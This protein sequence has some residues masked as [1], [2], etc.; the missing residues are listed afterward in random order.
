MIKR[1]GGI[2][3]AL[4][5]WIFWA[6]DNLAAVHTTALEQVLAETND[7]AL[8]QVV[9]FL[10]K[11]VDFQELY[12]TAQTLR[13]EE[14]RAYVVQQ[15]KARFERNGSAL[16][17]TLSAAKR[18]E[19]VGR[20]RPLWIA[21]AVVCEV[22][23][24][25]LRAC[26]AQHPEIERVMHDRRFEN[27]L[28]DEKDR[29]SPPAHLDYVAWGVAD[30]G[31]VRVWE[32]FGIYGQGVI[33]GMMDSGI[34]MAHPDLATRIWI[35]PGEDLNGNGSIEVEERNLIDDD[36]NGYID[37]F[38]GWN[39]DEDN[40]D[41]SDRNGHGTAT[42][43]IVAGG[44]T[45]CDTVGIAPEA[46]LMILS[47]Y[48][49]QS[50]CWL[51]MQYASENG[52]HLISSSV[53]FWFTDCNRYQECP[54]PLTWRQ[55]N[56]IELAAGLV[57]VNSTGN[58][59]TS[60]FPPP[61]NISV[62]GCSPPPWLSPAQ[63]LVGGV[64]SII[65]VTGYQ[66]N[67]DHY[68]PSGRG[69]SAW[70][71][72]DLCFHPAMPHCHDD[73]WPVAYQ[74]YPYQGGAHQGLLK[75]EI[76]APTIVR[77]L[78]RGGGCR[79]GFAGTS[80][81]APHIGGTV[82]LMMSA[83]PGVSPEEVCRALKLTARDA[84][85]PGEDS[86]FGAGKVD[87]Y[88]AVAFLLDS[89]GEVTGLVTDSSTGLPLEEVRVTTSD[90][91][92]VF[93]G[94]NGQYHLFVRPGENSVH[95]Y[96]YGYEQTSELVSVSGGGTVTVNQRLPVAESGTLQGTVYNSDLVPQAGVTVRI[97]DTPL[98]PLETEQ[99][100]HFE[101]SVAAGVYQVVASAQLLEADTET[102]MISAS[103]TTVQDFHLNGSPMLL[104]T[105]P[106]S[107]G[108]FAW[109]SM[110]SAGVAYNWI[111]INPVHGGPGTLLNIVED[112]L[113]QIPLPFIF[114]FYGE[115]YDS[116]GITENGFIVLGVSSEGSYPHYPIPSTS[117]PG[118]MVAPFW[119]DFRGTADGAAYVYYF[120]AAEHRFI[121]EWDSA[122]FFWWP[123]DRA[124]F[125]VV[126]YDP[127]HYETETGDGP[128]LFQYKRVDFDMYCTVGIENAAEDDGIQYLFNTLLDS[129]A[130]G[131]AASRSIYFSTRL[132]SVTS[133]HAELPDVF[134]L[135]PCYPN[136]FNPTTTFEWT[137][138]R[139]AHVR[140]EIFDILGRHVA[141]VVEG[142]WPAGLHRYTF[143]GRHLATGIYFARFRADGAIVQSRKMLLL[144]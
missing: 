36:G 124:T 111:E 81:A 4:L 46:Q 107:Y 24:A 100:G 19:G 95:F 142:K 9:V 47:A 101:T 125:E 55:I 38:Y 109:D 112:Q 126:L 18:G 105:G 64:S 120:D 62:P 87:A 49:W 1:L 50:S 141:T 43:G 42:A 14:R 144:K 8:V 79:D 53:S 34:D 133:S 77:T 97:L 114:Q 80:A 74:D 89:L 138:P 52:A 137:M 129:H 94:A 118:M 51:A 32:E 21:N 127:E 15:L 63:Q 56:E 117:G 30:I 106:D 61:V 13:G 16:V 108:Y 131:I 22:T 75:P 27:T 128:I 98:S 99:N 44:W 88:A 65:A 26:E 85:A 11:P 25:F 5:V 68:P 84:G 136:P 130:V 48:G 82:A 12:G 35:N 134:Y 20:V 139:V 57:H 40:N 29:W 60:G 76:C 110:D 102:V 135:A 23:P 33:V 132:S 78:A 10:R 7:T 2:S 123:E 104:P 66:S 103:E 86:L 58:E 71:V 70:S 90:S 39:F 54:D 96:R 45:V 116:V 92:A 121:I 122:E 28:D 41:V 37:D 3:L 59:G 67:G 115:S 6:S 83:A 17:K 69:P 140:L 72:A 73:E 119:T 143:D 31:A 91:R 113:T 93:T